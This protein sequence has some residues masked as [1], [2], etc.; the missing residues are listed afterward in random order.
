MPQ[1]ALVQHNRIDLAR[2][3]I[4]DQLIDAHARPCDRAVSD[5]MVERDDHQFAAVAEQPVQAHCPGK[6]VTRVQIIFEFQLAGPAISSV[7]GWWSGCGYIVAEDAR[8]NWIR[9]HFIMKVAH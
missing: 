2:G 6:M 4:S 8:L 7:A 9:T 1:A 5:R 3:Q